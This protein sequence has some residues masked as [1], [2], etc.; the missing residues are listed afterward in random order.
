[1][2]TRYGNYTDLTLGYTSP[3]VLRTNF[4]HTV[5][6]FYRDRNYLIYQDKHKVKEL[7][8]TRK[9]A[10]AA[11]GYQW[12]RF[13]DTY[14]RYRYTSDTTA[15]VLGIDPPAE[16]MRIGSLALLS[17][18]R[19]PGQQ[20][21]S[22]IGACWLRFSYESAAPAYGGN[23]KYT[24]TGLSLQQFI[25]FGDRHTF[26]LEATG[27][28]GSGTFP[29]EEKY[30]LGGADYLISTPLLGY[31][32]R[33]FTGDDLMAF[34]AA[35]RFRLL[36]YQLSL[37]KAVLPEP[38]LPGGQ[39]LEQA[40][41]DGAERPARR[42][43]RRGCMPIRSS[44]RCGSILRRGEQNRWAVYVFGRVRFLKRSSRPP[45]LGQVL[46]SVRV[47][48]HDLLK[49]HNDARAEREQGLKGQVPLRAPS[50]KTWS[51]D[52]MSSSGRQ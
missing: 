45:G 20:Q 50:K 44:G 38:G 21:P 31:Q 35:Y 43:R 22:P 12:F 4:L 16:T 48:Q 49:H 25:P 9:G 15:E 51:F 36:D 14:L 10:E 40:G 29:Y 26:V 30:G 23:A 7:E 24:K 52:S 46:L 17:T 32:R 28:L 42:H 33:E 41:A 34:S 6:A 27:G 37:V 5:D 18:R 47:L 19:H 39:C 13:G 2:N 1:M 11:F 3:V 8:I